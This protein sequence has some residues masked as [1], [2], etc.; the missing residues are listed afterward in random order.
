MSE[1]QQSERLDG[2][3]LTLTDL[4]ERIA[5]VR[6]N[7]RQL[8]EQATADSGAEHEEQNADRIMQQ[9][10]ELDRLLDLREALLNK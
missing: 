7:I 3:G 5:V 10:D 2:E 8:I 6:D 1:R 9:S 4:E